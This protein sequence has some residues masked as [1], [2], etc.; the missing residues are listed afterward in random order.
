MSRRKKR[1][2]NDIKAVSPVIA[3]ILMV[4]VTVVFASVLYILASG[5]FEGVDEPMLLGALTYKTTESTPQTG[6]AVF[7]LSLQTMDEP[8]LVEV[9]LVAL[10]LN[11]NVTEFDS[12][13]AWANWTHIASDA[14]DPEPYL[15]TG[16]VLTIDIPD[17]DIRGYEIVMSVNGFTGTVNVKIP[18]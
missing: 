6:H 15:D 10:N 13:N 16:D 8:K 17:T 11:S 5:Y 7:K 2:L 9:R 18:R 3:T 4:A 14:N 1:L 12:V